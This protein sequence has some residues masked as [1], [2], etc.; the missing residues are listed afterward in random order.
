MRE[1]VCQASV[2][3][4]MARH[5]AVARGAP[6]S[7]PEIGDPVD[8]EGVEFDKRLG[9]QEDLE[10]LPGREL[11]LVVLLLNALLAAAGSRLIL[12]RP[13]VLDLIFDGHGGPP[14]PPR[15]P[16]NI[17]FVGRLPSRL[18]R[19]GELDGRA[20]GKFSHPHGHARS[21]SGISQ[22]FDEEVG[23]PV[24]NLGLVVKTRCRGHVHL[25][26]QDLFDATQAVQVLPEYAQSQKGTRPGC[27]V[28]FLHGEAF[29]EPSLR[30]EVAV[31]Q[32]KHTGGIGKPSAPSEGDVVRDRCRGSGELTLPVFQRGY[33]GLCRGQSLKTTLFGSGWAKLRATAL[34][35]Y[36]PSKPPGRHR[37]TREPRGPW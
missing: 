10:P 23:R 8:H 28:A 7:H 18:H 24:G 20:E 37:H 29:P 13:E 2:D 22:D 1:H 9:I 25:G 19:E 16:G 35:P 31:N 30:L 27:L 34:T 14:R 6:V 17:L 26:S 32:R 15:D 33:H 5:D 36:S 3:G 12:S 11:P 4:P 21:A